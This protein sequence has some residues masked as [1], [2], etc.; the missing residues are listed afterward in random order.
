[1]VVLIAT[2]LGTG[3]VRFFLFRVAMVGH[4]GA[5]DAGGGDSNG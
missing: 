3:L 5:A 2:N 4:R 1:L